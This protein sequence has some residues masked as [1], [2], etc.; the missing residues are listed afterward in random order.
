MTVR[1]Y[2]LRRRDHDSRAHYR[3]ILEADTADA[4]RNHLDGRQPVSV[5]ELLDSL[6]TI[7]MP[8]Q[9]ELLYC[10]TAELAEG[11]RLP[12]PDETLDTAQKFIDKITHRA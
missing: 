6:E 5:A 7:D 4:V 2:R 1:A 8:A 10:S 9:F 3:A 12:S 11:E